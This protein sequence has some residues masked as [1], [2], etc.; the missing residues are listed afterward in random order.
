M[1]FLSQKQKTISKDVLQASKRFPKL[2]DERLYKGLC[3]LIGSNS[4]QFMEERSEKH[5][6]KI[7]LCQFFL[8]NR[9]EQALSNKE[10]EISVRIFSVS[11][12]ICIAALFSYKQ[13]SEIFNKQH[14]LSSVD[15]FVAGVKEIPGSFYSRYLQ[16]QTHLFC[17]LEVQKLRGK[18]L[19]SQELKK[20]QVDLQ[21][22][23]T[24]S[25]TTYCPSVFW[26]YNHEESY[27]E[28][29]ILNKE[30]YTPQDLP[31]ASIHFQ[32]LTASEVEFLVH[33][34]CPKTSLSLD[35]ITHQLP[36][37]LHSFFHF[38]ADFKIARGYAFS[39]YLPITQ[40]NQSI[41]LIMARK[42][43]VAL[44]Q[45]VIG[46]F[47]DF[48]GGL[49]TKQEEAFSRLKAN[50]ADQIPGFY[51]FAEKLFYSLKPIEG[52]I[53]LKLSDADLLFR[54]FSSVMHA[55]KSFYLQHHEKGV[56]VIKSKERT[57]LE[58][59][60]KTLKNLNEITFAILQLSEAYYFVLLD[61]SKKQTSRLW[62]QALG[63][64]SLMTSKKTLR[65]ALQI[66]LPPSLNP[67]YLAPDLRCRTI[68]KVLF[69]GLTRLNHK[70]RAVLAGAQTI[71][72][73]ADNLVY[74]FTLRSNRWS[75]GE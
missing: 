49:F 8:Q 47:R 50:L 61:P 58:P 10:R 19:S 44:L 51:L 40:P 54:T 48:N 25:I 66:G 36:A 1:A 27:R 37:S 3:V 9:I 63:Q 75:D 35:E 12:R 38:C 72:C 31:Q 7:L 56:L 17:Y 69:E 22:Q 62:H 60:I 28:V 24:G 42:S 70:G 13:P 20:L 5:L 26:P 16:E 43:V 59:L 41:N 21:K 68:Y 29:F 39:I 67:Y 4:S 55:K 64:S 23:I 65:L 57:Q 53:T 2:F 73:S 11:S 14:I 6:K 52:Q 32:G 46:P 33:M 15:M 34:A 18:E 71:H 45:E 74:T 30:I